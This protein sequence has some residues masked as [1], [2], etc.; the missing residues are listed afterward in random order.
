M[1]EA[2]RHRGGRAGTGHVGHGAA[3][4]EALADEAHA[5][6]YGLKP[7]ARDTKDFAQLA[8]EHGFLAGGGDGAHRF[9]NAGEVFL[10]RDSQRD[11]DLEVP[12]LADKTA[13]GGLR[14]QTIHSFCQ[15]LLAT[16]PVEAGLVPGFRPLDEREQALLARETLA[17]VLQ[18]AADRD[19]RTLI[20]A[21]QMLSIRLGEQEAESYLLASARDV[22][23]LSRLPFFFGARWYSSA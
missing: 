5:A 16:F 8:V 19:D 14:I 11:V 4:L 23:A 2:P 22:E 18:D 20:E 3:A 6:K 12:G 1:V 7:R 13:G 9:C 17:A 15:Q 21:V 10:A